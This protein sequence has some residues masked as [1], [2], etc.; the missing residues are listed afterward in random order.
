MFSFEAIRMPFDVYN[1]RKAKLT[2]ASENALKLVQGVLLVHEVS[3][4]LRSASSLTDRD[5]RARFI[6]RQSNPRW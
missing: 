4:T 1:F 3:G 2:A 5:R 6:L